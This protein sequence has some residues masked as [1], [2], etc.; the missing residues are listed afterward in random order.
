MPMKIRLLICVVGIACAPRAA[1]SACRAPVELH[2]GPPVSGS[3]EAADCRITQYLPDWKSENAYADPYFVRVAEGNPVTVEV[4]SKTK[5]LNACVTDGIRP[6]GASIELKTPG[7]GTFYVTSSKLAKGNYS[8]EVS[9]SQ[10][11]AQPPVS[12]TCSRYEEKIGCSIA[13]ETPPH[14]ARVEFEFRWRRAGSDHDSQA[15]PLVAVNPQPDEVFGAYTMNAP[16]RP[17]VYSIYLRLDGRRVEP[18]STVEA[19]QAAQALKPPT[20]PALFE[21]ELL[22]DADIPG[23]RALWCSLLPAVA[24]EEFGRQSVVFSVRAR[25]ERSSTFVRMGDPVAWD[26]NSPHAKSQVTN[27]APPGLYQ[28]DLLVNGKKKG[29]TFEL[30]VGPS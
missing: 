26:R 14:A 8:V 27:S 20:D 9:I 19:P 12:Y 24:S 21:C 2:P 17:G 15:G 23:R 10:L 16:I 1:P 18:H 7:R 11:P 30:R 3:L 25:L 5:P 28:I 4:T 22:P 29:G 6:C 13:R